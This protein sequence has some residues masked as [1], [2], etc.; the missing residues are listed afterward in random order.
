MLKHWQQSA[1]FLKFEQMVFRYLKSEQTLLLLYFP[2]F[3]IFY[4]YHIKTLHKNLQI[5]YNEH[6]S[7]LKV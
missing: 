6:K 7:Y 2:L 5:N 4:K 3:E 1:H